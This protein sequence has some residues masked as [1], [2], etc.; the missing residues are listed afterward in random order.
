MSHVDQPDF[1]P[2]SALTNRQL[3]R[4]AQSRSMPAFTE[5]VSRFERRLF[6][7]LLRR[8]KCAED[9]ED[10]TQ[11]AFVR[12]WQSID[13][14]DPTWEF[15]TWLFTIGRRLAAN[16]VAKNKRMP[17]AL[18][19]VNEPSHTIDASSIASDI[20]QKSS[21]W[22][23]VQA[24]LNADQQTALWLRYGEQMPVQDI[25][26]VLGKTRVSVRV[27]LF[28]ARQALAEKLDETPQQMQQEI[29]EIAI[30]KSNRTLR[31]VTG[32]AI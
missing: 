11:E 8:V 1:K 20:E 9:A 6:N 14:Y 4:R 13:R 17:K 19:P 16:Q 28:R 26:K 31:T 7:F 2:L 30:Q 15:S 25:A 22:D 10:I 18:G 23:L 5:L 29:P 12:A 27:M 24:T 21:L 3:A 32:G